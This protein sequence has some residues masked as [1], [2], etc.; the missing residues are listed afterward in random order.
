MFFQD[1]LIWPNSGDIDYHTV[2][3]ASLD[4][5]QRFDEMVHGNAYF[6]V[7]DLAELD[8]QPDLK[9]D[10]AHFATFDQGAGYIIYDLQKAAP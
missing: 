8:R 4:L 9:K 7:T 6:L 3:G 10:L 2:R 5:G 1:A